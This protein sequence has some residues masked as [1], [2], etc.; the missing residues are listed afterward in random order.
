MGIKPRHGL[1]LTRGC[2]LQLLFGELLLPM[3]LAIVMVMPMVMPMVMLLPMV[4]HRL[5]RG[6][7]LGQRAQPRAAGAASG[8][9]AGAAGGASCATQTPNPPHKNTTAAPA[10]RVLTFMWSPFTRSEAPAIGENSRSGRLQRDPQP[11]RASV[12]PAE[13]RRCHPGNQAQPVEV[14]GHAVGIVVNLT[15]ENW[16]P[17]WTFR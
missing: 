1:S 13:S 12:G 11:P 7:S 10:I 14:E 8:A 17:S 4:R 2:R 15:L 3:L 16:C 5:R 9:A 6:R